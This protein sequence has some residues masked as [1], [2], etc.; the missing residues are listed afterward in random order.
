MKQLANVIYCACTLLLLATGILYSQSVVLAKGE[1]G[2]TWRIS[3]DQSSS[4]VEKIEMSCKYPRLEA[5]VRTAG[6]PAFSFDIDINYTGGEEPRA[7]D[8]DLQVP[9]QFTYSISPAA[10]AGANILVLSLD[11]K[12]TYPQTVK[13]SIN[14]HEWLML[15]PGEYPVT[16][17]VSS[18]E[19]KEHL[20]LMAIVTARYGLSIDTLNSR[21]NINATAGRDNNLTIMLS[22][23]STADLAKI[24]LSNSYSNRPRGWEVTFNPEEIK[25]LPIGS[26]KEIVVNIKPDPKTV[27][28]SYLIKLEA[29]AEAGSASQRVSD[30]LEI[31]VTALTPTIWGWVG[32]GIIVLIIVGLVI[33]FKRLGRR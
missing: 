9:P 26:S 20:E 4:P 3:Q 2:S 5:A 17:T 29:E 11:P 32:V 6:S 19:L 21:L 13:L 18:G 15:E 23:S 8:L 31:R 12:I 7:F 24:K 14:P 16:F 30:S 10:Q 27:A 25:S 33:M 28:G 22:N 1:A